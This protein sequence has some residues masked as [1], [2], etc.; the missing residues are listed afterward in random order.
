M[1]KNSYCH[2]DDNS[3]TPPGIFL[4]ENFIHQN[5]NTMKNVMYLFAAIAFIAFTVEQSNAQC[6]DP[7]KK[8]KLY[9][10]TFHADYCGSCKALKPN[11]MA[12]QT[13]LEGEPVHFLKFDITSSESKSASEELASEIGVSELYKENQGTGFVLLVDADT[14]E[15]VGKL[16]SKQSSDDMYK[17]VK[18]HL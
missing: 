13:K 2:R 18:N 12:L 17:A 8:T 11:L 6:E 3:T 1:L 4:P 10:L 15:T 5:Q 7:V 14:K 9:A 16:T